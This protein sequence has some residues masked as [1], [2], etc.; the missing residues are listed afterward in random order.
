M[1]WISV[2]SA[3]PLNTGSIASQNMGFDGL[4]AYWH[5]WV[6]GMPN[7]FHGALGL[8]ILL[9]VAMLSFYLV[10]GLVLRFIT[11]VIK[12]S[13]CGWDDVFL[14][15]GVFERLMWLLPMVVIDLGI[16][17]VP[18]L[19]PNI[20]TF[21]IRL[22]V[23]VIIFTIIRV[24][25]AVLTSVDTLY[26]RST[27][28]LTRPIK[29]YL[30]VLLVLVYLVGGIFILAALIG[31][32]PWYFISG[33]GAMTALILLVFR[34]TLLSLVASIQITANGLVRVGDWI[35]IPQ[36]GA[37]GAIEDIALNA[38]TIRNWDNTITAIPTHKFLEHSFKNWRSMSESGGRRIK[39]SIS[40]DM[41]SIAF[42]T[43]E[44][45]ERFASFEL[46][47]DY[48]S[49]KKTELETYNKTHCPQGLQGVNSRR[50]TNIGT[51]RY[52]INAYLRGHPNIHQGMT[53]LIRQLEPTA[54][55]VPLEIYV[56]TNDV[57][58]SNYESIQADIFDHLLAMVPEFGLRVFQYPSGSD[59]AVFASVMKA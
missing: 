4:A 56:F 40:I 10:R 37:D 23:A 33:I 5:I 31:R 16:Y 28:A 27:M 55:G 15:A 18:N 12:R 57:V 17:F 59:L 29:G 54:Q 35:E 48:I 51:L 21:V 41:S 25:S 52:Y 42:L 19:A 8:A 46:L 14:E 11:A 30:Q 32:S 13:A 36:F 45:M 6:K 2:L 24:L 53:L 20:R 50:L 43:S 58:W 26:A 39:R 34:D 38:V 1:E 3:S 7:F 22:S 47:R 44:Q 49:E 9:F